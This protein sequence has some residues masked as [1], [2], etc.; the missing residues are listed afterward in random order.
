MKPL[1]HL[2]AS[3]PVS[4]CKLYCHPSGH[5]QHSSLC[6]ARA[7]NIGHYSLLFSEIGGSHDL[8]P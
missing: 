5:A 7:I 2:I 8:D 3:R 4:A 6:L 1:Q